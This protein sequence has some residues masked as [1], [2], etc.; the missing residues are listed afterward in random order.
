[1]SW[2]PDGGH[3]IELTAAILSFSAIAWGFRRQDKKDRE[4]ALKSTQKE[5][6]ESAQKLEEKQEE[7]HAENKEVMKEISTQL[8]YYPPHIHTE[9]SGPLTAE[10]IYPRTSKH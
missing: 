4:A 7:R 6:L 2:L 1:M 5:L 3:L 9:N 10:N 8:K